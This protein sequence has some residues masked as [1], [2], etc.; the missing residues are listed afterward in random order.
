M[1]VPPLP[2][3]LQYETP[4]NVQ[5]EYRPAGLGTRFLAWFIDQIIL[6]LVIFISMVVLVI[7]SAAFE[8]LFRDLFDRVEGALRNK[9]NP[10]DP[11]VIAMYLIGIGMLIWGLGSFFYF[12]LSEL[13]WRGQTPGKRMCKIRVVK[14]DGFA[15]DAVGVFMRNVFRVADHLPVLWIVPV[16]SQRGQRFG[17][18]VASTIVISDEA[19]DLAEVRHELSGR[20]AAESRFRFDHAKLARLVRG[21]FD[22]VERILDRWNSLPPGQQ[23][24]LLDRMVGPLCKKMQT[25]QPPVEERVVFLE[26]LLAAEYRRQDRHLR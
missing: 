17:D 25:D 2:V 14:A 4:E 18:M 24:S 13:L 16:L 6:N 8:G 22:A 20:N 3:T 7:L 12:G 11:E 15:L 26:D 5:I 10:V 9:D 1:S 23:T 19:E 21:D